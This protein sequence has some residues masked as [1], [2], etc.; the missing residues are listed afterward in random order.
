[1]TFSCWASQCRLKLGQAVQ[2]EELAD[3]GVIEQIVWDSPVSFGCTRGVTRNPKARVPA[4]RHCSSAACCR[5]A[6]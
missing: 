3:V 1:M 6:K 2:A 4:S 5:K